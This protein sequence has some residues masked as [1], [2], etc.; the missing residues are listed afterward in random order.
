MPERVSISCACVFTQGLPFIIFVCLSGYYIFSLQHTCVPRPRGAALLSPAQGTLNKLWKVLR[1]ISKF[2]RLLTPDADVC[3]LHLK[4]GCEQEKEQRC[5]LA[6]QQAKGAAEA[7][8]SMRPY[9]AESRLLAGP[10]KS[11]QSLEGS[12]CPLKNEGH[13]AAGVTTDLGR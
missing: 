4:C 5:S 7:P 1:L 10:D 12:A 6:R 13:R 9:L 3:H 8:V 11:C 2:E